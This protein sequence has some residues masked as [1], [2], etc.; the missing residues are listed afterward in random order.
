MKEWERERKWERQ[1]SLKYGFQVNN[2]YETH[3]WI[4]IAIA[5]DGHLDAQAHMSHSAY[6]LPMAVE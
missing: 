5:I 1:A 4:G 3:E 2:T 6:V